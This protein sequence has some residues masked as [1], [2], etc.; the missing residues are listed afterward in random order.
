M[1]RSLESIGFSSF[2]QT[3]FDALSPPQGVPARVTWAQADRAQLLGAEGD[4]EAMVPRTLRSA[5]AVVVAGDWVSVDRTRGVVARVLP[6]RTEFVR[7]AAGRRL[8]RQ[9][10]A[11]NVD[12][13]FLLAGLDGDFNPR[14]LE[15]YLALAR[16]SGASPVLLLTK[17]ALCADVAAREAEAKALAGGAPVHAIDVVAGVGVEAPRRYLEPGVSVALIGSSG[18]GKSTLI[19]H[20][21]GH[22]GSA[23]GPVREYDA[24]GRHTTTWRELFFLPSGAALLDTPGMRE[25]QLWCD[26]AGLDE[27]FDDLAS[28]SSGCRFRDCR[29]GDEPGCALRAAIER[30][31]L[32]PARLASFEGLRRE[33]EAHAGR[34]VERARHEKE[35]GRGMQKLLRSALHQK[36]GRGG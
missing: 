28:L 26:P 16:A 11:A 14:R 12:I 21:I 5:G 4:F 10:V 35:R 36:Y 1:H 24:R 30:G 8:E 7:Q 33:V 27:A 18:V 20:L 22:E 29:H 2:F 19:N 9:I 32:E 6:R 17:A 15:R 25:V 3:A 23:T 31:E 34:Q 13:V